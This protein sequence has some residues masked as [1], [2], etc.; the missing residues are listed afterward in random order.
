GSKA[1]PAGRPKRRVLPEMRTNEFPV[2]LLR[3]TPPLDPLV[4]TTI[5]LPRG[6]TPV[7]VKPANSLTPRRV[8]VAPPSVERMTPVSG[9]L[10]KALLA[11][12]M[13]ATSTALL[14]D[15]AART[16]VGSRASVLIDICGPMSSSGC[17]GTRPMLATAFAAVVRQTPP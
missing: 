3:Q 6:A 17:Q 11:L 16:T 5:T 1:S 2:S 13:P 7:T 4:P 10:M 15:P 14:Y 8:Q 9:L 12:P